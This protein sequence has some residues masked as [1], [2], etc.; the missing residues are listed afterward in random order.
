MGR[1][2]SLSRKANWAK[3]VERDNKNQI[4]LK[5]KQL[6]IRMMEKG[7]LLIKGAKEEIIKKNK[8][9]RSKE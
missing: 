3:G 5:K 1:V 6:E 8:K 9:I 7:Q 2:D 4:I